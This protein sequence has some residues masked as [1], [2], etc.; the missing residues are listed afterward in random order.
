MT[1]FEINFKI[2]NT[3]TWTNI[4]NTAGVRRTKCGVKCFV[5]PAVGLRQMYK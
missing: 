4:S 3:A 1:I 2:Y 5:R